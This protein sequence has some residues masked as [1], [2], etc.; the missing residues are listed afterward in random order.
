V[1]QPA[2]QPTETDNAPLPPD[3]SLAQTD[4]E[5]WRR[6]FDKYNR[7]IVSGA[8]Q[9]QGAAAMRPMAESTAQTNR[10]LSRQ[11][12]RFAQVWSKFGP[13]IDREMA[14]IPMQQRTLQAYEYVCNMV[15]GRHAEELF[16]DGQP[17]AGPEGEPHEPNATVSSSEDAGATPSPP[18]QDPIDRIWA[19]DHPHIERMKNTGMTKTRLRASLKQMGQT[20]A[21]YVE[22][23]ER[24]N[25]LFSQSPD[26]QKQHAGVQQVTAE[27]EASNE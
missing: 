23:L 11:D 15:K 16:R 22:A 8:I 21:K 9:E 18:E 19:S 4:P 12:P 27:G 24:G 5:E 1:N 7:A 17:G 20:P 14:Q 2:A 13:E 6:Q 3:P 26:G 10:Q 25:M